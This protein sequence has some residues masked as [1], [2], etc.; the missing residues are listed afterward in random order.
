MILLNEKNVKNIF[1]SNMRK[2]IDLVEEAFNKHIGEEVLLPTKISQ[3][4]DEDSQ[5]RIN[6]MVATLVPEKVSGIKWVSVF[7]NN[8]LQGQRNVVGTI[9]LSEIRNGS[10]LSVMDGTY[11]TN[12]RTAAVGAVAA[13]YLA[14]KESKVIGFIGAGHEA[15][16]H[17]QLIKMLFPSIEKCFVSSRRES[18]VQNFIEEE[19]KKYSDVE[20]VNCGNNYQKAT[21]YADI[22]VTATS[23]QKDLLK[24]QWIKTGALYI[25]VGGWED[26]FAVAQKANKIVCDDWESVKH[27]SQTLSRM[28]KKGLISDNDVYADIGDIIK[29]KCKGRENGRE[30]IY[31]NSVGLAFIDIMFANYVYQQCKMKNQGDPYELTMEK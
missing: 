10:T 21:I 31:F 22:I 18:T 17:F 9:V 14:N 24:A 16:M 28:Y 25:H 1:Q 4:F 20:Y 26:E 13:K 23:T 2:A 19:K 3:I 27:R 5:N 15:R 7:P 6:C 29:G 30:F 8:P 11:I 12:I